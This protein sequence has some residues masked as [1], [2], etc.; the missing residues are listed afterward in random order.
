MIP[1]FSTRLPVFGQA[2]NKGL[3][4]IT[5]CGEWQR[6]TLRGHFFLDMWFPAEMG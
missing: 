6:K 2:G 3:Y 1:V 4:G 5:V